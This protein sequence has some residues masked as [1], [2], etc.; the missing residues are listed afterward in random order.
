MTS[1]AAA[2]SADRPPDRG[3]RMAR[4]LRRE[5]LLDS[6]ATLLVERGIGAV[7]MEGVAAQAGV[8]KALPYAHFDNATELVRGLRDR[9]LDRFGERIV[10]ATRDQEGYEPRVR[11]AV[12]AYF[13]GIQ[14]STGAVLVAVLRF[15]PM[16][17]DEALLR[18]NPEFFADLLEHHVGLSPE[19]AHVAS[20][21][22]VAGVSG[23]VDS[24]LNGVTRRA[25][26]E[27]VLCRLL[28][29]GAEGLAEDERTGHLPVPRS[30]QG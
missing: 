20:A 16:D 3:A 10:S 7:T 18:H 5:Q 17:E 28:L 25:T 30:S 24:W 26:A 9:E 1:S 14:A 23:A 6:A 13:D 29:T 12:H 19:I 21:V 22:F 8:S 11:A 15:A 2:E 27:A 4:A